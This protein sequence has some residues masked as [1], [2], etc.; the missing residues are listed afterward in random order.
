M[1][2]IYEINFLADNNFSDTNLKI[3]FKISE[4]SFSTGSEF[5]FWE[6]IVFPGEKNL[7]TCEKIVCSCGKTFFP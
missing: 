3:H 6:I 5:S 4:G 2:S 7:R 1:I